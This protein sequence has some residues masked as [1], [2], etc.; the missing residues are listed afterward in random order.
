M[1]DKE[2]VPPPAPFCKPIGVIR[3]GNKC[4]IPVNSSD[5]L[6][7]CQNQIPP[8]IALDFCLPPRIDKWY[9]ILLSYHLHRKRK[10]LLFRQTGYFLLKKV[11]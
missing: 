10:R 3:M 5:L 11:I 2:T 1:Q 7:T 4:L 8:L 6:P 9:G